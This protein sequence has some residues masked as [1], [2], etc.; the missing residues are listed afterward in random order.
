MDLVSK[1]KGMLPG[2]L[3]G[4][5]SGGRKGDDDED[6]YEDESE[7]D[8]D[9]IDEDVNDDDEE[10]DGEGGS[11]VATLSAKL[12]GKRNL[13][14]AAAGAAA[15]VLGLVGTAAWMLIGSSGDQSAAAG[16]SEADPNSPRVVID[17]PPR[18]KPLPGKK[19]RT[20]GSLNAIAASDQGPGAGIVVSPVTLASFVGLKELAVGKPLPPAPDQNL[21]E[22]TEQG[23]LPKID[24]KGRKPWQVYARP[25]DNGN[26]LPEVSI[27][28]TGMGL[29]RAATEVAIKRLPGEVTL[30]FDPYAEGLND[31]V[32]TAR[33]AGHEVLISLPLEPKN[34][35]V[36]D[37]GPDALMTTLGPE[38]N[39][40]RLDLVLGRFTGYVGV[41]TAMG[42][43][44]SVDDK[45]VRPMLD[46]LKARGL[47]FVDGG[48]EPKTVA[49][50]IATEIGLPRVVN[51]LLL[52]SSS[53]R[54]NIDRMLAELEPIARNQSAVVVIAEASPANL[55]RLIAWIATFPAKKLVLAPVSAV[56]DKQFIE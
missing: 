46:A 36:F 26:T 25:F 23:P 42:S 49:P 9:D 54:P 56:A 28:V 27:I 55:E 50:R 15:V 52:I 19:R 45:N 2:K 11:L 40:R 47:M 48:A 20:S 24:D 12:G 5:L 37:P 35:P 4:M 6:E 18:P 3:K 8:V 39:R 51:N 33:A 30:A 44:F 13:M 34:F 31:S 32:A 14:I 53:S 38:E 7:E 1:L 10:D 41:V 21:V 29:S 43:K 16:G 22:Q 17:I